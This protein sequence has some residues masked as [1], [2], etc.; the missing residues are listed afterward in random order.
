MHDEFAKIEWLKARFALPEEPDSVRLG[1]GDDAALVDF[2]DGS[3]IVTVDTHVEGVHFRPEWIGWADVGRRAMIA[4][5]SDVFAMGGRP[6]ASVVAMTLPDALNDE[7]FRALAD[8]IADAARATGARVVGGNLSGG[9]GVS[10]TTTAFG[11]PIR[12]AIT[13]G[14]ASPGDAVYVTGTL[15]ASALGLAILESGRSDVPGAR[16]FVGRWR[17]PPMNG[18]HVEGLAAVA[19]AAIDVSDGC[20]QD[21]GHLCTASHV[22][23]VLHAH[24]LPTDD[25]HADACAAL[26]LDPLA[27]ALGGGEDYELLFTAPPSTEASAFATQIGVIEAGTGVEVRDAAGRAVSVSASGFRH[28]S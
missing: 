4:A 27:L 2:G 23:G 26:D 13:R 7:G 20:I 5:V 24:A 17:R 28:F 8:G 19:S 12:S 10:I 25:G 15:G 22:R 11:S 18:A 16:R 14:G 9:S 21:L 6:S 3:T 1:I